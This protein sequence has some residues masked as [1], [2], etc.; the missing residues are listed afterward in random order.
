[1]FLYSSTEEG[2]AWLQASDEA[3]ARR[4]VA[5]YVAAVERGG[6]TADPAEDTT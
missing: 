3:W 6:D 4:A 5:A 2:I 1:M